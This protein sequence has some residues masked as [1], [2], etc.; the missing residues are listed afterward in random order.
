[1]LKKSRKK[2]DEKLPPAANIGEIRNFSS[3]T[4]TACAYST[5]IIGTHISVEGTISG[6]GA[7]DIEGSV[8]G[9]IELEKCNVRIG[10]KGRVQ[11]EILARNVSIS[12]ELKGS[13]KALEKVE[14][15]RE[16]DFF[17][18]IKARCISVAD[19]AHFKGVVELEREPLEKSSGD[20]K[21][22]KSDL[23][24]RQGIEEQPMT[25]TG[26]EM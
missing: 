4:G 25:G 11:G 13:I 24:P 23:P 7:L 19:G 3:L 10:T 12:G 8:T 21:A 20:E 17:G 15:A 16:A 14:V 18:E 6:E 2:R 5:T 26:K 1:M 22:E 9:D